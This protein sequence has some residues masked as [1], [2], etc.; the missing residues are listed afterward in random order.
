MRRGP[1]P[2][3]LNGRDDAGWLKKN[4]RVEA[5]KTARR[6]TAPGFPREGRFETPAELAN[7]F[8]ED[9]IQCLLCGKLYKTL[10]A[11]LLRIHGVTGDEYHEKY[12]IPFTYGLCSGEL[13]QRIGERVSTMLANPKARARLLKNAALGRE[14]MGSRKGKPRRMV[15]VTT[16]K[17]LENIKDAQPRK[18]VYLE[19]PCESCGELVQ[20]DSVYVQMG[21]PA[22]CKKCAAKVNRANRNADPERAA[23][24]RQVQKERNDRA[25]DKRNADPKRRAAFL[26]KRRQ[27]ERV[28]PERKEAA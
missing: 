20:R 9:K 12:G 25:R 16:V 17:S 24:L 3:H 4:K 18:V 5:I 23:K 11:H 1:A 28:N 2:K 14:T 10:G 13:S 8:N 15:P 6:A 27:K 21:K 26:E 22:R 19:V 7:Y